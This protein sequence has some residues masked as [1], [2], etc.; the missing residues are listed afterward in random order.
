MLAV[1]KRRGLPPQLRVSD[2][3]LPRLAHVSEQ[4][5]DLLPH[6][7]IRNFLDRLA[8][9]Y[10][11]FGYLDAGQVGSDARSRFRVQS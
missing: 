9:L 11:I 6:K 1:K 10:T 5:L 8:H 3:V 7:A 4:G 2:E